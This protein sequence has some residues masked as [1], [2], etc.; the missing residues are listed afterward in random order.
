MHSFK[1]KN[2]REQLEEKKKN[3]GSIRS[4]P[5][6][7]FLYKLRLTIY[8]NGDGKG[9]GTHLGMFLNIMRGEYD[10]ILEWPFRKRITFSILDMGGKQQHFKDTLKPEAYLRASDKQ[11]HK[12]VSECNRGWGFA[13]FISHKKLLEGNFVKDNILTIRCELE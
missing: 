6:I 1:I 9:K 13:D 4:E 3:N 12:P 2:F 8:L 7:I 5:F 11:F 10:D